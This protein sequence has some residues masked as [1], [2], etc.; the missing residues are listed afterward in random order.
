M[1]FTAKDIPY[2]FFFSSSLLRLNDRGKYI[3]RADA[4]RYL[5]HIDVSYNDSF[6]IKESPVVDASSPFGRSY[7]IALS[8]QFY[9]KH[10]RSRDLNHELASKMAAGN[11]MEIAAIE[12]RKLSQLK[13][14]YYNSTTF[15]PKEVPADP[16]ESLHD[17]DDEVD[18]DWMQEGSKK[19]IDDFTVCIAQPFWI[20]NKPRPYV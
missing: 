4:K 14:V 13:R 17:T 11:A 16:T 6:I 2:H 20:S 15:L 10:V 7:L 18:E 5:H 12:K 3:Y 9:Y 1:M 8:K 19:L